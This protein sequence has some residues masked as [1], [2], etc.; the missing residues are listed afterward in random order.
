MVMGD[1]MG[2]RGVL[3]RHMGWHALKP[4]AWAL[5][6]ELVD[7]AA[8]MLHH[9]RTRAHIRTHKPTRCWQHHASKRHTANKRRRRPHPS[10]CL[11]QGLD[12]ERSFISITGSTQSTSCATKG[13]GS[14][15]RSRPGSEQGRSPGPPQR[16]CLQTPQRNRGSPHSADQTHGIHCV[17][18]SCR[19]SVVESSGT[20][21]TGC[22]L[23]DAMAA[24]A[25]A[26][27][28]LAMT[29]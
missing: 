28:Q 3:L 29:A 12:Y 20:M 22:S 27:C 9:K 5:T 16:E 18:A 24:V 17:D 13:R 7:D 1:D 4:H 21:I 19:G 6:V 26:S 10:V 23:W 14:R 11:L 8:T 2:R 15:E 25:M